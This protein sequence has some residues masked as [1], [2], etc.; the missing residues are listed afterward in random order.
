M[1][2]NL[3]ELEESVHRACLSGEWTEALRAHVAACP[4]CA[5][6]KEVFEWLQQEA[7]SEK[8]HALPN[9]S[10][11]WWKAQ[12]L[13]RQAMEQK[14]I[15]P[16]KTFQRMAFLFTILALIGTMIWRWPDFLSWISR[17]GAGLHESWSLINFSPLFATLLLISV[18]TTGLCVILTF[19]AVLSED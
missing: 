12:L 17:L 13:Q 16:L 5:E 1:K 7:T 14:A 10:Q 6:I 18:G 9:P 8:V 11:L 15:A 3:C 4:L 2:A 19:L